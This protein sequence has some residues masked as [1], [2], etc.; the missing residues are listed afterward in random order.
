MDDSK[1][2][3]SDNE[4]ERHFRQ[5]ISN[6]VAVMTG[7]NAV[8]QKEQEKANDKKTKGKKSSKNN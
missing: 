8:G 1:S 7:P 4:Y 3:K 2:N 6:D 5:M